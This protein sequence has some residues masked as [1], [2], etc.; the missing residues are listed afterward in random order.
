[1]RVKLIII[2]FAAS[3]FGKDFIDIDGVSTEMGK[4][5]AVF[6]NNKLSS[7]KNESKV[8]KLE[9]VNNLFN[10]YIKYRNDMEIYQKKQFIATIEETILSMLG[11][12]DDYVMAKFQALKFLGFKNNEL[13]F[14]FSTRNGIEHIKLLAKVENRFYVLD[15]SNP[16][17]RILKKKEKN[18]TDN[19]FLKSKFFEDLISKKKRYPKKYGVNSNS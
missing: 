13:V 17:F 4:R 12:C 9:V 19:S 3:L 5:R 8:K 6:F 14:W 7:I 2:M 18:Q 11:D 15:N 16:E 10:R 1:M